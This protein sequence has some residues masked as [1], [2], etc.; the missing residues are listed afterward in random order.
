MLGDTW[1][2]CPSPLEFHLSTIFPRQDS[3]ISAALS[4]GVGMGGS[5]FRSH[6]LRLGTA[7]ASGGPQLL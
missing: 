6:L 7:M 5:W 3:L 2:W 1:A 4:P